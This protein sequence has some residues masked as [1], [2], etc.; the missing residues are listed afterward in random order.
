MRIATMGTLKQLPEEVQVYVQ[1]KAEANLMSPHYQG[2]LIGFQGEYKDLE[3]VF[4]IRFD[5]HLDI[6][7]DWLR[8]IPLAVTLED[9]FV[10]CRQNGI[11]DY[12]KARIVVTS[13][14]DDGLVC[15]KVEIGATSVGAFDQ[16][17]EAYR[18][19]RENDYTQFTVISDWG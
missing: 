15:T 12:K 7:P 19:V 17:K 10:D 1:S 11:F 8:G 3:T 4:C 6:L 14:V 2:R 5:K 18:M 9:S 16:A 13:Y